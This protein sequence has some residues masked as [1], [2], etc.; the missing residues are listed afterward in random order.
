MRQT[1][2]G[3]GVEDADEISFAHV[4]TAE[5]RGFD[6]GDEEDGVE[7]MEFDSETTL[8]YKGGGK[9][10]YSH[11]E[12]ERLSLDIA[13][14]SVTGL[15]LAST[16]SK[17]GEDETS[18]ARM[19]TAEFRGFEL[20][21]YGE[22]DWNY[23]KTELH[24]DENG[25]LRKDNRLKMERLDLDI[26]WGSV[27]GLTLASTSDSE[28]GYETSFAEVEAAEFR[29]FDLGIDEFDSK[30]KLYY[31]ES[32]KLRKDSHL[33]MKRLDLDIAWGECD[34][35]GLSPQASSGEGEDEESFAHLEGA[36]FRG[37]DLGIDEFDSKTKLYYKESGKLRKDSHL[38]MKR[39]DLDIAWGD[40]TGLTL[41]SG[42]SGEGEDEES[43]AHLEASG[44]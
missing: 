19:E 16:S 12:M 2:L 29:V 34:R 20:D 17:E 42:S 26:A 6:L 39:L 40:V 30:T 28:G 11:L 14:G 25:N 8:Y 37:F 18:F 35:P 23:S 3:G 31:K 9:R 41:A 36:E 10:S 15:T 38:K 5:F 7:A 21:I 44:V 32:G 1:R 33:K 4:E 24:Y 13:W 22:E 43:F 27:T